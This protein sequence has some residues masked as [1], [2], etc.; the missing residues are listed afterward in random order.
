MLIDKN[1]CVT[2]MTVHRIVE[3]YQ[4][5]CIVKDR[6]RS[7]RPRS[8]NT[9]HKNILRD[10]KI[11]RRKLVSGFNIS[12]RSMRI[13][14]KHDMGFHPYKIRRVHVLKEKMKVNRYE[15]AKILLSIVL[16]CRFSNVLVRNEKILTV[17]SVCNS[18]NSRQLL[19]NGY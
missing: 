7:G 15:K 5:M 10:N 19:R 17:N 16:Q 9:S 8:L 13:I 3:R 12:P 6:P 1:L 4:K 2:R 11:L 14:V 18:Q